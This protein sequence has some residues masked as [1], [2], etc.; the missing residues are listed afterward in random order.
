MC[1][2]WLDA[3]PSSVRDKTTTKICSGGRPEVEEEEDRRNNNKLNNT[4]DTT[5]ANKDPL[6]LF[7][8]S[9]FSI[10]ASTMWQCLRPPSLAF[11]STVWL[12]L[13]S[14]LVWKY[15]ELCSVFF[16]FCGSFALAAAL[17]MMASAASTNSIISLTP[18][19]IKSVVGLVACALQWY[20]ANPSTTSSDNSSLHEAF[21]V[22]AGYLAFD[23]WYS[24]LYLLQ[25][26]NRNSNKP[27]WSVMEDAATLIALIVALV[28]MMRWRRGVGSSTLNMQDE[29]MLEDGATATALTRTVVAAWTVY[30]MF[31]FAAVLVQQP[32][33]QKI[34]NDEPSRHVELNS[35]SKLGSCTV[36]ENEKTSVTKAL[37]N[38]SATLSRSKTTSSSITSTKYAAA[39]LS[40]TSLL[41][42][43]IHGVTYDLSS[44]VD[45]HPGGREAILLGQGR[46]DC[47]ALF[48]SYHPFTAA[49]AV[50]ILRKYR[51]PGKEKKSSSSIS[52]SSAKQQQHDDFYETLCQRVAQTLRNDYRFDPIR[53]RAATPR[54]ALYYGVVLSAVAASGFAH[55]RV[56]SECNTNTMHN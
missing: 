47:T 12:A 36:T 37:T 20:H 2:K 53:D 33:S 21:S 15:R 48:Q 56:R 40:S 25:P 50:Q 34:K 46:D 4:I 49:Q 3:P 38:E 45:Q 26:Q 44:Y 14:G 17:R 43:K 51:V 32:S 9:R 13:C 16:A 30:K 54:R 35:S 41:Y 18:L 39:G 28:C 29:R 52:G 11:L 22:A 5:T 10:S 31:R 1:Q 19:R 42:W 23:H 8:S 55:C 24:G 27:P 6:S 7:Q